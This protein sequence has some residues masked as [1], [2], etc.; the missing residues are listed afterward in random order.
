MSDKFQ[1]G[2]VV[3]CEKY[4]QGVCRRVDPLSNQFHYAFKFKDG[5]FIWL[6]RRWAEKNISSVSHK[7]K[8]S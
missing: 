8:A 6:S 5:T 4:G 1:P 2:D 7:A 3:R